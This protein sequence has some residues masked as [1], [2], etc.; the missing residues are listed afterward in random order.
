[1]PTGGRRVHLWAQLG[2]ARLR[3]QIDVGIGDAVT[4]EPEWV[5]LPQILDLP[6]PR[7]RAYRPETSIAEKLETIVARGLLNSRLKDYFD[8]YVLSKHEAFE[9]PVLSAAIRDTFERRGTPIPSDLSIGLTKS[10]AGEAGKRLQWRGF[11]SK[12]G[13]YGIPEDLGEITE[14]VARF[15]GPIFREESGEDWSAEHW[16]PGGPWKGKEARQSGRLAS[17]GIVDSGYTYP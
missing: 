15:L 5:E 13:I 6:A 8:I 14:A 1:M 10:F 12:T 3:I 16:E 2:N 9:W 4:P 7:L 17:K 11:L